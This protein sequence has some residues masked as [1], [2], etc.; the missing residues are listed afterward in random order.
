MQIGKKTQISS[1]L[2]V[3]TMQ[4][5]QSVKIIRQLLSIQIYTQLIKSGY[6]RQWTCINLLLTHS[7]MEHKK[8]YVFL[9]P[10]TMNFSWHLDAYC[11]FFFSYSIKEIIIKIDFNSLYLKSFLKLKR[12]LFSNCGARCHTKDQQTQLRF[13][14]IYAFKRKN[15]NNEP[16]QSNLIT[17]H[18]Y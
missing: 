15:L 16:E 5:S 11:T 10:K 12:S 2:P 17:S 18:K 13:L 3:S 14:T 7:F 9:N 4:F 1:Y 8:L 6:D